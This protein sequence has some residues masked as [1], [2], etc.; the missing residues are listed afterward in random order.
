MSSDI[1]KRKTRR[2]RPAAEKV[3]IL[4]EYDAAASPLAR[5]EI[6]RREGVYSSLLSNWRK[7]IDTPK[8]KRG[9]RHDPNSAEIERLQREIERLRKRAERA[10]DLVETLGKVHAFLQHAADKSATDSQQSK[11]R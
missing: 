10:E 8:P 1:P 11:K 6:M 3:R 9:R 2:E 7:Q 4:A 5:A